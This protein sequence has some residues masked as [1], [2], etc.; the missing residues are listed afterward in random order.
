MIDGVQ[1]TASSF[2]ETGDYG[3]WKPIE[4][5]G[6][7]YGTNGFYL[8]F[9]GGGVM[10]ATGGDSTATDGDYKAASFTSDGTFT[11]S[12]DG[13]VEYLVIA[14]GGAG[15]HGLGGGGAGGRGYH[16][17]E[18]SSNNDGDGGVGKQYNIQRLSR[19]NLQTDFL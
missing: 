6:L 3:E 17:N 10:S 5:S 11:P 18:S 9:A 16:N 1:L 15:G 8:S 14:G 4:V 2:G 12:A 19:R 13:Y 7:T